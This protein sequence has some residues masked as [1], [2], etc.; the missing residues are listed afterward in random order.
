MS[1]GGLTTRDL[2]LFELQRAERNLRFEQE[3]I[4]AGCVGPTT[5]TSTTTSTT[6]TT[7]T[8]PID[9]CAQIRRSQLVFNA[10]ID[11]R[12]AGLPGDADPAVEDLI[13]SVLEET[14]AE[15]NAEFEQEL[16]RNEC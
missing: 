11:V 2:I 14:R 1:S 15:R 4:D 12:V 13:A 3:L 6:T 8:V 16:L 9:R 5:T 7:T 10:A